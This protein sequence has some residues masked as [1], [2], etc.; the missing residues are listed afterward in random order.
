MLSHVVETAK[1]V[2]TSV[3][4]A[5]VTRSYDVLQTFKIHIVNKAQSATDK[6]VA[7]MNGKAFFN[8]YIRNVFLPPIPHHFRYLSALHLRLGSDAPLEQLTL[9]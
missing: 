9:A 4:T 6:T 2:N 3:T 1:T 8:L 7:V 5:T